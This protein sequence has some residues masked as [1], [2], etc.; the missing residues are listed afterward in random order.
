MPGRM[1]IISQPREKLRPVNK[2]QRF[3]K[4]PT[5]VHKLGHFGVCVTNFEK[6]HEFYMSHF[7]FYPSDVSNGPGL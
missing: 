1:L 6:S 3:E 7:N 4:R 2:T 5:P